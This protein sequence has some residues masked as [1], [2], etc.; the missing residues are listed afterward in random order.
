MGNAFAF[1]ITVGIIKAIFCV[2]E[3]QMI[4][5]GFYQATFHRIPLPKELIH[6]KT[7]LNSFKRGGWPLVEDYFK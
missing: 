4:L 5:M 2:C 6:S 1:S 3:Y 7:Q